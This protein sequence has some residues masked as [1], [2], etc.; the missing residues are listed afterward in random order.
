KPTVSGPIKLSLTDSEEVLCSLDIEKF[1]PRNIQ[2]KW[3][4]KET[5]ER[6]KI[7]QNNDRT[8]TI[9]SEYKL[10]GSFFNLPDSVV[11]VSWKHDSMEDW[12]SREMS[13]LDKDFP[14][15]PEVWDIPVPNLFYGN[16]ATLK[17]K[18]SNVFPRVLSVKWLKKE[19]D[20]EHLFP[21]SQN[22]GYNIS[23][24]T[25]QK[26]KD[27]TFTYKA[28]L[29]FK[30]SIA[31]EGEEFICRVEHPSLKEPVEKSTGPLTIE[32]ASKQKCVTVLYMKVDYG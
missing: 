22:D 16:T 21:L 15:K 24:L 26:Q 14:W 30:P 6:G 3:N 28:C 10:P 32:G 23:E 7:S 25:P 12:E 9:N 18:V 2:I 13:V 11:R 31:D 8:Y 4:N 29:K 27:N 5:S 1:Y 19:K 20:S 17:C